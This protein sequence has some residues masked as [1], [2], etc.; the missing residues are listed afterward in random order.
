MI[1]IS[2]SYT[3]ELGD[4]DPDLHTGDYA[5]TVKLVLR[6]TEQLDR[7]V[8]E[9]H[10]KRE[11]GQDPHIPIDEFMSIARG[12]ET[13]GVDPHPVKVWVSLPDPI[14]KQLYKY[15]NPAN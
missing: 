15:D 11:P 2:F 7:K 1:L 3:E 5:S 10:Q 14:T 13:Y 6:Q 8:I 9:L 12:L 4:Y